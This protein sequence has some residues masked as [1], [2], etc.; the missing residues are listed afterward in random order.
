[1]LQDRI[2]T[3]VAAARFNM[4][5]LKQRVWPLV[6]AHRQIAPVMP[7]LRER[8]NDHYYDHLAKAILRHV[9]LIELAKTPKIETTKFRTRW[10]EGL[11]GDPRHCDFAGCVDIAAD[12][13]ARLADDWLDVNEHNELLRLCID[14]SLLPYEVPLDYQ[15]LPANAAGGRI[16]QR[17]NLVWTST[18]TMLRTLKLRK[19]L[20]NPATSPDARFFRK[21]IADKIKIK[22]YLTDRVLTGAHK[23]N[24]EKRWEAHPTSVHFAS[25]ST[26]MAI[27]YTLIRQ[28]CRFEGFPE[29]SRQMQAAGILPRELAV[30]RCPIT[31]DSLSF[32]DFRDGLDN[33]THGK[34]DFHVG[35]LNPL[36]LDEPGAV[37]SGHSPEN[38]SWISAD[39][40]RIQG[41]LSLADVQS[42][43][44]RIAQQMA[45]SEDLRVHGGYETNGWG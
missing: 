30:F 6:E 28:L 15:N 35:H 31:M 42:L 16:H 14:H 34:S 25:R 1:M 21:V 2:E 11:D 5:L 20:T 33:P 3:V 37:G 26:C 24:R 13:L 32:H 43:L 10:F 39:G 22:T 9:F 19:Y 41:S 29:Q 18:P 27:E 12:L 4:A 38:I 8:L 40:N 45:A 23:T 36:K 17:G 7:A 44:R